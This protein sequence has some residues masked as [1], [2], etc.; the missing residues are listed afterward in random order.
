MLVALNFT[1]ETVQ[2]R[3]KAGAGRIALSTCLDAPDRRSDDIRLRPNEG[4]VLLLDLGL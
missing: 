4:Q 2:F 1:G 3:A